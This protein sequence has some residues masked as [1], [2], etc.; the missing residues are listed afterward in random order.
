MAWIHL[1]DLQ[2]S[3][4]T[5]NRESVYVTGITLD[6]TAALHY[7]I[8]ISLI[9]ASQKLY[10]IAIAILASINASDTS[11]SS[12]FYTIASLLPSNNSISAIKGQSGQ[13]WDGVGGTFGMFTIWLGKW[14]LL[15]N[16]VGS[17]LW[18]FLQWYYYSSLSWMLV[19]VRTLL[20]RSSD[21]FQLSWGSLVAHMHSFVQ[22]LERVQTIIPLNNLWDLQ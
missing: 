9:S 1:T 7:W 16:Q 4:Y 14:D 8:P 13:W 22:G 3:P 5:I 21:F 10:S 6:G 12:I 17:I 20:A 19:L 18:H 2:Y 15:G 11:N